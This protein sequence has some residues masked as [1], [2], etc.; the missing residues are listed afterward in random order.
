MNPDRESSHYREGYSYGKALGSGL[1]R[2][3]H[4]RNELETVNQ[5]VN[6]AASEADGE[7]YSY[8][9]GMREALK[10]RENEITKVWEGMKRD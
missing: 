6:E 2:I 5:A 3:G 9:V 1:F 7:G 10:V 4:V 8:Y